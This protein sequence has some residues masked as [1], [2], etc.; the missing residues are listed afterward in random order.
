MA[1]DE[2][3]KNTGYQRGKAVIETLIAGIKDPVLFH[4]P[5]GIISAKRSERNVLHT[6]SDPIGRLI[7]NPSHVS[8][9]AHFPE[10]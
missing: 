3:G 4:Q 1:G 10:A 8:T 5:G 6:L 9:K 2:T 7:L